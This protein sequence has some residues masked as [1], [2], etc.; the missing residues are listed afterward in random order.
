MRFRMNFAKLARCGAK[1]RSN[2]GLP[3]R[4]VALDNGRCHYHGGKNRIKHGYY[5]KKTKMQKTKQR[6]AIRE[7]RQ[8]L[9]NL[10]KLIDE[11]G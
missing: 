7:I 3:C 9:Y 5:M 4:H 10:K 11:E 1:A 8:V 6:C 2:D